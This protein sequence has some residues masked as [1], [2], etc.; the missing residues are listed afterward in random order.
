MLQL[1]NIS[2]QFGGRVL[3]KDVNVS[4][5]PGECF[6][7]IGANGAGKSTLLRIISGDLEPTDGHVILDPKE[8]LSVLK[9]DH[10]AFDEY[11]VLRTVLMGYPRLIQ[12]MDEKDALYAKPDFSEEDG[13][14]AAELE[15]EFA[16]MDG[17]NAETDAETLLE[18][19]GVSKEKEHTLMKDMD[20]RDKVKVL[21]AQALFGNPDILVLDEPTN[22]LDE[23]ACRW[24]E[25]FLIEFENTVLIVSHDRYFLNKVCT[26]ILDVDYNEINIFS[27]NYDFWYQSSQLLQQQ[28]RDQNKKKE[29]RIKELQDFIRRFAANAAKSKQ[30]TSRKKALDKIELEEMKPSSRKYPFISFRSEYQLGKDVLE[31]HE[32]TKEGY[33][34]NLEFTVKNT[35]KIAFIAD[36][37]LAISKLFDI[38]AGKDTLDSGDFKWGKTT[39]PTYIPSS[40]SEFDGVQSNLVNYLRPYA[41]ETTDVYLRGF[42][43]RMLFTGE[44]AL[45]SVSVLSGGEKVRLRFCKVMLDPGNV[46]MLDDPTN[47]LDLESITSLNKGMKEAEHTVMLFSSH[48]RELL[49][50]IANRI[51]Y[52]KAD[53]SYI[54]REMNYEDFLAYLDTL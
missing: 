52:I 6:G 11:T 31:V 30:A 35:D 47:H 2:M 9:Q 18:S 40:F 5:T 10:D 54:D 13:V 17:W 36:N 46:I 37:S 42:L 41:K 32:A 25:E 12:I 45:K 23:R 39:K 21:L 14:K 4:F 49:N 53:G 33:F 16:E 3:Y 27:G 34:K 1:S 19:L 28:M 8:R 48:D 29:E 7:I 44:E 38:F 20:A 43:G 15:N 22:N 50:T 26:R 24:L 51:I